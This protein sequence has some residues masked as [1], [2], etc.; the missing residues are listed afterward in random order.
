[1][2]LVKWKNALEDSTTQSAA[3]TQSVEKF[4]Q[5]VRRKTRRE[6]TAEEK[7]GIVLEGMKRDVSV[8]ELCHREGIPTAAY[9]SWTKEFMEGGKAQ[10]QRDARRHTNNSG[11]EKLPRCP[12]RALN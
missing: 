1:M 6:F 4:I 5:D 2:G 3:P 7:I 8:A 12:G 10:L 11:V 9:Y